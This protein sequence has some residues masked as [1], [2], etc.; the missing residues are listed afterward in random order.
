MGASEMAS[1]AEAIFQG[2]GK[3]YHALQAEM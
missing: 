1:G 3:R 2:Y